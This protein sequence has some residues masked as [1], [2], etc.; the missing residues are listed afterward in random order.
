MEVY[1][2]FNSSIT[3]QPVPGFDLQS[4]ILIMDRK[5]TSANHILPPGR[6]NVTFDKI[7]GT[8]GL[9]NAYKI[10]AV[11]TKPEWISNAEN[12]IKVHDL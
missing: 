8:N 4:Y 12:K 10:E 5:L 2:R 11:E 6:A 1:R 3:T 7:T 9:I